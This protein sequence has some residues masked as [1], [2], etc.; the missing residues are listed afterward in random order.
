[1]AFRSNIKDR[2]FDK[3]K[4]TPSVETAVRVCV[5][6]DTPVPV[7]IT[8]ASDSEKIRLFSESLLVATNTDT[9]IF[10]YTVP[11]NKKL[12]LNKIRFSGTNIAEYKA[13]LNFTLFDKMWTNHG[14]SLSIERDYYG[15]ELIA[16]DLLALSVKHLRP[17][18]GDFNAELIGELKDD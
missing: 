9:L 11:V 7:F 10:S 17:D 1:M 6:S 16:G 14:S 3:F 4:Q 8:G 5:D 18:D 2:E 13:E 12:V 15:I